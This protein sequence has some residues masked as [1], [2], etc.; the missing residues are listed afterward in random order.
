MNGINSPYFR[1]VT[2]PVERLKKLRGY[3]LLENNYEFNL[4]SFRRC[5]LTLKLSPESFALCGFHYNRRQLSVKCSSCQAE[6]ISIGEIE[7]I[8]ILLAKHA[9][10]NRNCRFM[11]PYVQQP[12]ETHMVNNQNRVQSF[13]QQTIRLTRLGCKFTSAQLAQL[14]LYYDKNIEKI[15]CFQC[16]TSFEDWSTIDFSFLLWQSHARK[17]PNCAYVIRR[18][19]VEYTE[20]YEEETTSEEEEESLPLTTQHARENRIAIISSLSAPANE[21]PDTQL[22][23]MNERTVKELLRC[24]ICLINCARVVFL[25]CKHMGACS[26]CARKISARCHICNQPFFS[27]I[28]I[29]L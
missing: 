13:A 29:F 10:C 15:R 26:S 27:K 28:R 7:E 25:P 5:F 18:K 21:P 22:E 2:A 24:K 12:N 11:Q 6:I 23:P 17:S 19:G 1:M 8:E 3:P 9:Q 14:G 20:R 16:G 4:L